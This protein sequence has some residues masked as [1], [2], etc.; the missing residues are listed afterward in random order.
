M[1]HDDITKPV[2]TYTVRLQRKQTNSFVSVKSTGRSQAEAMT[3]SE[4]SMC[5]WHA[6]DCEIAKTK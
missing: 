3:N 1:K 4:K 2:D 5:G 6:I